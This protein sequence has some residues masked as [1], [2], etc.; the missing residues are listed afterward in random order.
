[1]NYVIMVSESEKN[2][3]SVHEH[4][5]HIDHELCHEVFMNQFMRIDEQFMKR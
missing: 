2:P 5:M 1:M 4:F 3:E